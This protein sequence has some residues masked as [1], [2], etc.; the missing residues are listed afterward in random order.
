MRRVM[1]TNNHD[2]L[3]VHDDVETQEGSEIEDHCNTDKLI[4]QSASRKANM[5]CL[6]AFKVQSANFH[7]Q[8]KG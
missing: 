6:E 1:E 3:H 7:W 4:D 8:Y 2:E 5:V